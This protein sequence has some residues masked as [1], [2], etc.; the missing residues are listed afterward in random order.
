MRTPRGF[1]PSFLKDRKTPGKGIN[2]AVK[3]LGNFFQ[4]QSL[5][6]HSAKSIFIDGF[7]RPAHGKKQYPK[8]RSNPRAQSTQSALPGVTMTTGFR[9]PNVSFPRS[10]CPLANASAK[11]ARNWRKA[12]AVQIPKLRFPSMGSRRLKGAGLVDPAPVLVEVIFL[13]ACALFRIPP[14]IGFEA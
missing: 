4:R 5:G 14:F 10:N 3:K 8:T 11:S 6:D 1:T 13:S 2:A 12:K 7:A 9:K